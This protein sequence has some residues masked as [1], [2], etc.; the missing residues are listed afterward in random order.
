MSTEELPHLRQTVK[1][2]A[3][4]KA[5]L[6]LQRTGSR[7]AL[8]RSRKMEIAGIFHK[9]G[10]HAYSGYCKSVGIDPRRLRFSYDDLP[11]SSGELSAV[12]AEIQSRPL[13]GDA[14]SIRLMEIL[15]RDAA[16]MRAK[17]AEVMPT[18]TSEPRPA[19]SNAP[20]S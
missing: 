2:D 15:D 17:M 18:S 20:A 13:E 12:Q 16:I 4:P 19:R 10:E 3:C 6:R 1:L 11:I 5:H 7:F 14:V 8:D 9:A